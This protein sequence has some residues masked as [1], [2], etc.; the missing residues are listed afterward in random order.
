MTEKVNKN[1][2]ESRAYSDSLCSN[3]WTSVSCLII[4][5][6]ISPPQRSNVPLA[7]RVKGS[8]D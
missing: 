2:T 4:T 6:K 8:S 5:H 7:K 3:Y 1:Q